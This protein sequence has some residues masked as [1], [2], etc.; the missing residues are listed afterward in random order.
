MLV[1]SRTLAAPEVGTRRGG[2]QEHQASR[3]VDGHRR[4]DISGTRFN[5]IKQERVPRPA[6][7]SGPSVEGT[8]GTAR[9]PR[10]HIIRDDGTDDDDISCDDSWRRNLHLARPL[11][12]HARVNFHLAAAAKIG[13]WHARRRI[14]G[15]HAQVVRAHKDA[16]SAGGARGRLFV[17]PVSDATAVV[18]IGGALGGAD[19]RVEPPLRHTGSWIERDH[20]VER[21]A[22]DEAVLDEK[23]RC[24][25]LR[26]RHQSWIAP[27]K[28]ACVELPAANEAVHIRRGY[29]LQRRKACTAA[30]A[31][32]MVPSKGRI[33]GQV[34]RRTDEQQHHHHARSVSATR[35]C[36]CETQQRRSNATTMPHGGALQ[37]RPSGLCR[38][39]AFNAW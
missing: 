11:E 21:R 22:K 33:G 30:I 35:P 23:R 37:G 17:H 20:L 36:Q 16:R 18:A 32:P 34:S 2:R 7:P 31:A 5:S 3:L 15:D 29:L 25:E 27:S 28:V 13:A 38:R 4:P 14:K 19:L 8:Y 24:L 1:V 9:C 39:L 6:R 10:A 12:R 26:P